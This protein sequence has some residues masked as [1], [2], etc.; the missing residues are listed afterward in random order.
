MKRIL[1]TLSLLVFTAGIAVTSPSAFAQQVKGTVYQIT[2]T[3]VYIEMADHTAVRIPNDSAV[4]LMNGAPVDITDLRHGNG[5]TVQYAP[6]ATVTT[7]TYRITDIPAA[8]HE[9]STV[10]RDTTSGGHT[11][12]HVWYDGAWHVQQ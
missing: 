10:T 8:P 12:H 11:V 5:V 4:F 1:Q 9:R 6:K 7:T 3:D 2:P